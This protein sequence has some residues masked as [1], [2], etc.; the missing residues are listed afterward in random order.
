MFT[1]E[2]A[3]DA[4]RDEAHRTAKKHFHESTTMSY[5]NAQEVATK[6]AHRVAAKIRPSVS[7]NQ[8]TFDPIIVAYLKQYRESRDFYASQATLPFTGGYRFA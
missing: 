5:D 7:Q 4:A 1:L 3:I 8:E 2:A 6:V